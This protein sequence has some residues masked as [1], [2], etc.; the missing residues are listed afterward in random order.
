MTKLHAVTHLKINHISS[1]LRP[2]EAAAVLSELQRQAEH[3][4]LDA[5]REFQD[6]AF[7]MEWRMSDWQALTDARDA[8]LTKGERIGAP[9][10][11]FNVAARKR[12]GKAPRQSAWQRLAKKQRA[13][14]EE[15]EG[16]IA[17]CAAAIMT[18]NEEGRYLEQEILQLQGRVDRISSVLAEGTQRRARVVRNE[19]ETAEALARL[20][21]ELTL[22]PDVADLDVLISAFQ[23]FESKR[24]VKTGTRG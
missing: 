23:A 4:L 8:L 9:I 1:G 14:L 16:R 12:A 2:D 20:A 11:K 5:S 24:S 22:E 6:I 18:R 13:K 7:E 19:E 10:S 21:L 17:E 15:I 3:R